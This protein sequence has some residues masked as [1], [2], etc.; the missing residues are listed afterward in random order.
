MI[1]EPRNTAGFSR[2]KKYTQELKSK[3]AHV[4]A[5]CPDVLSCPIAQNDWCHFTCRISRSKLH[6]MIK[7]QTSLMKMKSSATL[8]F[9]RNA[10]TNAA[11]RVLR[12][13][14]IEKG[15]ISLTLCTRSGIKDIKVRKVMG[16]LQNSA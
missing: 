4:A 8:V 13:P 5:P 15:Q 9:S 1:L 14:Y 7:M 10:V 16:T 11:S 6:K 3:G 12:H 2:I